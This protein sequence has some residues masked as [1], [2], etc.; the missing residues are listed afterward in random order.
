MQ[1]AIEMLGLKTA[2]PESIAVACLQYFE[3]SHDGQQTDDFV[4]EKH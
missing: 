2:C 4:R 1:Q 3:L